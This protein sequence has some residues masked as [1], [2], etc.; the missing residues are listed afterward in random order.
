M[1]EITGK[2]FTG[3]G[4]AQ[5]YL[6]M[7]E[8]KT[9]IEK[10]VGYKPFPGTLNLRLDGKTKQE[11]RDNRSPIEVEGFKKNGEKYSSAELYLVNIDGVDAAIMDLEISDYD[12]TVIEIIAPNNLRKQ[13]NLEDGDKITV[14]Y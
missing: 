10:A 3:M 11:I 4:V 13:L 9:R 1:R 14:K 7:Q 8:Y 2:L 12:D 6:S 5:E